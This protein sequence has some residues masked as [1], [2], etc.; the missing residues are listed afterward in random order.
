[1]PA[2]DSFLTFVCFYE[3]Y[4]ILVHA[5]PIQVAAQSTF[6][7][8]VGRAVGMMYIVDLDN[9]TDVF[10]ITL[11]PAEEEENEKVEKS[12]T[13]ST[14]D[15]YTDIKMDKSVSMEDPKSLQNNN[16]SQE[17]ERIIKEARQETNRIME[18]THKKLAE[19]NHG[20]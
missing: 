2:F 12:D 10:D 16:L 19:L 11:I 6:G 3:G 14:I 15:A 13:G 18:S 1:M 4:H 20:I 7:G 9:T 8:V 17:T 5:L